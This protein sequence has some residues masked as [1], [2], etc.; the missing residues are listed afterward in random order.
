[1]AN[2]QHTTRGSAGI[3]DIL[4]RSVLEY[5]KRARVTQ[6]LLAE[7]CG[8][9]VKSIS[10]LE[11]HEPLS[12]DI[13]SRVR[14]YLADAPVWRTVRTTPKRPPNVYLTQKLLTWAKI[15]N[16]PSE[17]VEAV[18]ALKDAYERAKRDEGLASIPLIQL[19]VENALSL[20]TRGAY[21]K[22]L[23]ATS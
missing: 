15:T 21:Y 22:K 19:E 4:I 14:E 20:A 10:R 18:R 11:R 17:S 9:N 3:D 5:R 8:V 6:A 16:Q 2:A 13:R 7:L 1:M 12:E 23:R